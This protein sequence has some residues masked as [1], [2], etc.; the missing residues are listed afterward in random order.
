M[1]EI[2]MESE[3]VLQARADAL[4]RLMTTTLNAIMR[5]V[6]AAVGYNLTAASPSPAEEPLR[7]AED[8]WMEAVGAGFFPRVVEAYHVSAE[9]IYGQVLE[10]YEG[11]AENVPFVSNE[12]AVS[13]LTD[14]ANRMVVTT[15]GTW[16]RARAQLIEGFSAGESIEELSSRLM[17]ISDWSERRAATVARTEIISASNAGSLAEMRAFQPN[18]SKMWLATMDNRTREAHRRADGE[19]VSLDGTFTVDG[20][21]LDFPGDP[22]GSPGNVINCRCTLNYVIP[23]EELQTAIDD[24]SELPDVSDEFDPEDFV[25]WDTLT[26]AVERRRS[27]DE[28]RVRRTRKGRFTGRGKRAMTSGKKVPASQI[29]IPRLASHQGP[30]DT[31]VSTDDISSDNSPVEFEGETVDVDTTPIPSASEK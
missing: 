18:A 13:Y 3:E 16:A 2:R 6:A 21:E 27:F 19:T 10:G 26:A 20:E 28:G 9:H 4:E 15:E 11:P 29:K 30:E 23:R 14:A 31:A 5:S 12:D 22:S 24:L 7:R 8:Q 1:V 25:D 17:T